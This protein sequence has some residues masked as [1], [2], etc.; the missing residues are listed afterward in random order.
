MIRK[1]DLA[2]RLKANER[3]MVESIKTAIERYFSTSLIEFKAEHA[4]FLRDLGYPLTEEI[5][6]AVIAWCKENGDWEAE[7]VSAGEGR[8]SEPLWNVVLR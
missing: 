6:R 3:T 5:K 7:F 8:W 4:I 2:E 1:S